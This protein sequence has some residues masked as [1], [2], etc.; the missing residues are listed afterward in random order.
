MRAEQPPSTSFKENIMAQALT[1]IQTRIV[2]VLDT[3][4]LNA[5]DF[6]EFLDGTGWTVTVNTDKPDSLGI[7]HKEGQPTYSYDRQFFSQTGSYIVKVDGKFTRSY[8]Q[9]AFRVAFPELV[10]A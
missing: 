2:E 6:A 5:E 8:N 4:G 3:T 1:F 10:P 9:V 7:I